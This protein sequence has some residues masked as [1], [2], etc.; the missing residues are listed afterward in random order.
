MHIKSWFGELIVID[1]KEEEKIKRLVE[2]VHTLLKQRAELDMLVRKLNSDIEYVREGNQSLRKLIKAKDQDIAV[3]QS[4]ENR[5][6]QEISEIIQ[7]IES[8]VTRFK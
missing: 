5:A 7:S 4:R 3:L 6:K 2:Q 1:K 8:V